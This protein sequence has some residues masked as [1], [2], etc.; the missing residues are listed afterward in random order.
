MTRTEVGAVP[1]GGASEH[2]PLAITARE[3]RQRMQVV[4][5]ADGSIPKRDRCT[6]WRGGAPTQPS[7][8]SGPEPA[9]SLRPGTADRDDR[10]VEHLRREPPLAR[11]SERA[12]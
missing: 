8:P 11:R 5:P 2:A 12:H 9:Q 7:W 6:A 4:I 1:S 3:A 10:A